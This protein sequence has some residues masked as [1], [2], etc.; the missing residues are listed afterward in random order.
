MHGL[1]LQVEGIGQVIVN[2]N[3]DW[4]GDVLLIWDEGRERRE[5]PAAILL[6]ISKESSFNMLRD[7]LISFL[8]DLGSDGKPWRKA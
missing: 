4:S 1:T 8:E 2:H 3:G 5:I 6:A 7:R